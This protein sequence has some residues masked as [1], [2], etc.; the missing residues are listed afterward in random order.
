[1]K[2]GIIVEY[3]GSSAIPGEGSSDDALTWEPRYLDNA[4]GEPTDVP[5]AM[6]RGAH[7][8]ILE[9]CEQLG[10]IVFL[11]CVAFEDNYDFQDGAVVKTG[12]LRV[13][14]SNMVSLI[15]RTE[16]EG[17]SEPIRPNRERRRHGNGG[18]IL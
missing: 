11:L 3:A 6:W 13:L 14:P 17:P 5:N 12:E 8:L 10:N 18:I 1:V 2:D 9:R 15:Q 7:Y 4:D 16:P